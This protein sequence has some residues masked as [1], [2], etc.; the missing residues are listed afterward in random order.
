LVSV[1]GRP[2][3]RRFAGT[4]SRK[5][6]ADQVF[7]LAPI[8]TES[9]VEDL[10]WRRDGGRFFDSEEEDRS[11]LRLSPGKHTVRLAVVV[12]PSRVDSG[13]GFRVIS[14]SLDL[15]ID[16]TPEGEA[17]SWPPKPEVVVAV[18]EAISSAGIAL[19]G[20]R[21]AGGTGAETLDRGRLGQVAK[22]SR[23]G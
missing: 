1:A 16:A 19:Q 20:S 23:R 18:K 7:T 5:V 2:A 15:T 10:E 6:L 9:K 22:G 14:P 8:W 11:S 4:A 3:G 12:T 17:A 21:P 13:D